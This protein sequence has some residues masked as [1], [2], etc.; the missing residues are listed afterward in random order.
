MRELVLREFE[1]EDVEVVGIGSNL[2]NARTADR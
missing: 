2:I 1:V